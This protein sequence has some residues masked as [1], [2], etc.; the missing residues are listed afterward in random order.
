M[1]NYALSN[2]ISILLFHIIHKQLHNAARSR[3]FHVTQSNMAHSDVPAGMKE[4][5]ETSLSQ[6]CRQLTTVVDDRFAAMKRQISAE[7]SATLD[8]INS[9]KARVEK[10]V[11]KS[12]GNEQQYQHQLDVL[13][14]VESASTALENQDI[15]KAMALLQEGKAALEAR[16]KL[17]KLADTSEHGWQ[18]VAEYVTNELAENSDDEKRIGRA[19][20]AAERKA[21][22]KAKSSNALKARR[23][24][25]IA[26]VT[27]PVVH[28][29]IRPSFSSPT[30]A[31][32]SVPSGNSIGPCYKLSS[33]VEHFLL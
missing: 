32:R 16:I 8:A 3:C 18:T 14:A 17:I 1:Q 20:R 31:V 30:M 24:S 11:F 19:E 21:K 25:S 26:K 2:A 27:T 7:Q 10:H 5:M 33:I 28:N 13:G 22:K 15:D 6:M 4:F 23:V 12:K 29:P 9:K